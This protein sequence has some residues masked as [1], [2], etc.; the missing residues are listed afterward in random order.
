M[1][2]HRV[3]IKMKK[4]WGGDRNGINLRCNASIQ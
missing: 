4:K 1:S 3:Q 2:R